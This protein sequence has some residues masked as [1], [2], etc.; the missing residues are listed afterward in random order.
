MPHAR[1]ARPPSRPE[2]T[3]VYANHHLDSPRWERFE[4]RPGDV[5]VTTA[6]K[7]GT[8]W[9]QTIVAHLV[10]R[11]G[12]IPGA[13]MEIS[14]WLDMRARDFDEMSR[15]AAA[16][17]HRRFLK[18]HLPLDGIPW[19]EEVRYVYVGRDLRDVFMSLWNHYSGHTEMAYQRL[20]D[21]ARLVGEPFPRCPDDILT[22][23]KAWS[24]RGWFPWEHDGWPYWSATH[25]AATWW[26]YRHLPNLLFVHHADLLARPAEEIAR[27]A[28]FLGIET[29]PGDLERVV[30]ATRFDRMKRDAERV[31]GLA[32]PL[33]EGGARQF[34]NRGTNGRWRDVLGEAELD[35]Y[36]AMV[37]RTLPPDCA[38]WLEAGRAALVGAAHP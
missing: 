25:H 36:R 13:I 34:V 12:E 1:S 4:T 18:T 38:R 26:A 32:A 22:L 2:V 24:S 5:V 10:F 3:R 7:A 20:N 9:M 27:V 8:T 23:W 28:R 11:G 30:R 33:W 19:R 29:P 21:P 37:A 6:Y 14:P 35:D 17:T 15:M 31:V 16:Q